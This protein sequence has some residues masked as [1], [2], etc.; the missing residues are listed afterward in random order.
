[1]KHNDNDLPQA[2]KYTHTL[3]NNQECTRLS[4]IETASWEN[5]KIGNSNRE[6]T[7]LLTHKPYIGNERLQQQ[8]RDITRV[9]ANVG[10]LS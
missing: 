4:D 7:G 8:A 2:V 6:N 5:V 1:M 9:L 10:I 3:K